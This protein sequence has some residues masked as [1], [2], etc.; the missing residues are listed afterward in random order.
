MNLYLREGFFHSV[1]ERQDIEKRLGE[2]VAEMAEM[3]DTKMAEMEGRRSDP[4]ALG[5]GGREDSD[6][7]VNMMMVM[8]MSMM[9]QVMMMMIMILRTLTRASPSCSRRR[10][11]R[12]CT[13]V[14]LT[15]LVLSTLKQG[16]Y[17][18]NKSDRRHL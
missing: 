1:V 5:A 9:D 16:T 8:M 2:K 3:A 17:M 4:A 13:P 6:L 7:V 14:I 10:S 15:T 11:S 12:L 18:Q